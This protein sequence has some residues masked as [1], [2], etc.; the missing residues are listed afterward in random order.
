MAAAP[1]VDT[2]RVKQL[3]QS[4]DPDEIQTVVDQLADYTTEDIKQSEQ[5]CKLQIMMLT[6]IFNLVAEDDKR[7]RIKTLERVARLWLHLGEF[8]KAL[9]QLFRALDVD[10]HSVSTMQLI[11]DTHMEAS[12]YDP[13]ITSHG[14]AIE[15]LE[16]AG[17]DKSTLASA[18]CRL[19]AV[20]EAMA[21]FDTA[22]Q[23]LHIAEGLA[24][25]DE[26]QA[27]VYSQLGQLYYKMG[28]YTTAIHSLSRAH[29][30]LSATKGDHHADTEEIAYLLQMSSN[31]AA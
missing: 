1:P 15:A 19:A 17:A 20:Y 5:L 31:Y 6:R 29:E 2:A 26:I 4:D 16:G 27:D 30:L 11:G 10:R 24:E 22:T 18:H 12:D 9:G 3:L 28:E 8:D 25:K 21:D 7:R 13:A 23:E 14:K